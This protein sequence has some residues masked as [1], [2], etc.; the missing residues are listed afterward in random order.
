MTASARVRTL[1]VDDEPIARDGLRRLLGAVAWI[2]CIGDADSGPAAVAAID[3]LKPELVFL[4]IQMPGFPGTEVLRQVT[5][6]P[7]VV[8]TT[9]FAQHAVTAFELGALDYLQKPF[10]AQ[11]LATALDRV[12]ALL[13]EPLAL[14]VLDRLA[15]AL[16][17]GPMTRLFVRSGAA[18]LPVA[19]G[20]VVWFEAFGD[21]VQA[22]TERARHILHVSLSR[23]ETRLDPSRFS[24]IH[25]AHVVNLDHV[26]AFRPEGRG[27]LVAVLRGGAR[28][29]VSRSRAQELRKLGV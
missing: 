28:L 22:H 24:R 4:D 18:I 9:A 5:H 1:I 25:R 7:H 6:R 11:R 23:L 19:V 8:F 27:R 15:E 17:Q 21:Y 16:G 2:E 12:R 29:A 20:S 14:P 10:G 26:T 3:R 13:G